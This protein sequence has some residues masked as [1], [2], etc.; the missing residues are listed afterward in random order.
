MS[1]GKR[2]CNAALYIPGNRKR[3]AFSV[4]EKKASLYF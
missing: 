2:G 4:Y 1:A 3:I